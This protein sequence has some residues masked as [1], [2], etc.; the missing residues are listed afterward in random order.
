MHLRRSL[1]QALQELGVLRVER[2]RP[3]V[4]RR[5]PLVPSF[6]LEGVAS[7]ISGGQAKRIIVMVR[8]SNAGACAA[9]A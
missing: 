4:P 8:A 7:L 2:P 1:W 5:R 9:I 6:D 3:A